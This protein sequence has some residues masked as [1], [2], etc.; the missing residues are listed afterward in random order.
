MPTSRRCLRFADL[1]AGP[2]AYHLTRS[3]ARALRGSGGAHVHD[4]AEV[5]WV[6]AGRLGHL[7][8]GGRR[9]LQA[10]EVAFVRPEHAHGLSPMGGDLWFMNLAVSSET[11]GAVGERYYRG[12]GNWPWHADLAEPCVLDAGSSGVE[13]LTRIAADLAGRRPSLLATESAVMSMLL[14]VAPPTGP[15]APPACPTWLAE[16][17]E[18]FRRPE[19][20]AE[21]REGFLDLAGRSAEHVGRVVRRVFCRPLSHV[22]RDVQLDAAERLLTMTDRAITQIALD[23]GFGNLG[24]F[25]RCFAQR[26]DLPPGRYRQARRRAPA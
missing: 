18:R 1:H 6:Q 2:G 8:S 12:A 7:T 22:L 9:V 19:H 15:T 16:A 20:L 23:C 10:G 25:Y 11:L 21:G 5:F 17:I 4:F 24:Y 3:D 26:F 14:T 13:E